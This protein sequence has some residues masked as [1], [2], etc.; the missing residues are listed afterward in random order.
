MHDQLR[1]GLRH[2][3]AEFSATRD[4]W[5]RHWHGGDMLLDGLVSHGYAIERD[6]RYAVTDAGRRMLAAGEVS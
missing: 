4:E 6:A 2:L 1:D 3:S 5:R